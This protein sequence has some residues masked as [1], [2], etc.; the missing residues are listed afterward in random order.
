MLI[1]NAT[2]ILYKND[3]FDYNF[4]KSKLFYII[5]YLH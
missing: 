3:F 2:N 4:K 5:C 1:F